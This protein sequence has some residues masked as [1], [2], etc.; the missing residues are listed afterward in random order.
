MGHAGEVDD[1]ELAAQLI[2]RMARDQDAR[3]AVRGLSDDISWD[4]VRAV[5]VTTPRG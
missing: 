1:A 4:R 2:D 5:D 3:E